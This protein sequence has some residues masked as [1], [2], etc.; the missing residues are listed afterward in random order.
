MPWWETPTCRSICRKAL[1]SDKGLSLLNVTV[2]SNRLSYRSLCLHGDEHL[3]PQ[4]APHILEVATPHWASSPV[5]QGRYCSL[6][7]E[8][9]T[10]KGFPGCVGRQF[11]YNTFL[12]RRE[13]TLAYV[14]HYGVAGSAFYTSRGTSE[15]QRANTAI[16]Q[17]SSLAE[18]RGNS[19]HPGPGKHKWY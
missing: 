4:I 16:K 18:P 8:Q 12:R 1:H 15:M 17:P 5:Q 11:M 13:A 10:R 3:Q 9:H 2:K 14:A 19:S 7:R 6:G